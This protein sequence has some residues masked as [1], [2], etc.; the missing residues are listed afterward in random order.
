L[1]SNGSVR[2]A[3]FEASAA[4]AVEVVVEGDP[5]A[6][7]IGAFMIER[8]AWSG[9]AAQLLHELTTQD[10]AEA[11]P[12]EWTTW[13]R[14]PTALSIRFAGNCGDPRQRI[15]LDAFVNRELRAALESLSPEQFPVTGAASQEDFAKR[16]EA[17]DAAIN[18]LIPIVILLVRWGDREGLLQLEKIFSRLAET[19][20]DGGGTVVWLRLRWYPLLVLLYAA[21]IAALSA[22]RFDALGV[23]LGTMVWEDPSQS[24]SGLKPLVLM[25]T[26]P[27]VDVADHFKRLPGHDRDRFP[28]SEHLFGLLKPLLDELLFLGG[29]YEP[30]F[31]RFELLLA[32]TFADFRDP[33]GQGD[34]WGPPGRFAYKQGYSNSPTSMLIDEA[35]AAGQAWPLL[36]S[37]LFGGQFER[38]QNVAEKYRQLIAR[39][40]HG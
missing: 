23:V 30:L 35:K 3:A 15:A 13:P 33:S 22:R 14:N 6:V 18:D 34:C 5:V 11:R 38:F 4:E 8:R 20:P 1:S 10:R 19:A 9:T 7:A 40:H 17:Y 32:L 37:G 39:H 2:L 21:G 25:V 27:L 12:T 36:S 28:R 26:S 24:S 16:I 31:D 29:N